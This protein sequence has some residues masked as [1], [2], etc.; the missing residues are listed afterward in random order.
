[1]DA[2]IK[3]FT[4]NGKLNIADNNFLCLR[5]RIKDALKYLKTLVGL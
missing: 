2:Y 1:M 5:W 4:S 3:L